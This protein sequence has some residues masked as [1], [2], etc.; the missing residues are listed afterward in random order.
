MP[1]AHRLSYFQSMPKKLSAVVVSVPQ[2]CGEDWGEMTPEERG[3]FCG[4]C[5]KV[6]VDF[7]ATTD[8][9]LITA[10]RLRSSGCGN[11]RVSQ[12]ER[13]VVVQ[14]SPRHTLRWSKALAAVMAAAGFVHHASAQTAIKTDTTSQAH[15]EYGE[16]EK[17]GMRI[18]LDT[19]SLAPG[20]YQRRSGGGINIGGGRSENTLYIVD[21]VVQTGFAKRKSFWRRLLFW[22]N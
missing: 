9:E 18:V 11:F 10:L 20:V 19:I 7:S 21:G 15:I 8:A 13:P 6:V 5:G 3:R 1:F 17:M 22:K 2:P 14:P 12:L 16:I 4:A